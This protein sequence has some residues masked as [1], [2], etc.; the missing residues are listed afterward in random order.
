M[1]LVSCMVIF[2]VLRI[3]LMGLISGACSGQTMSY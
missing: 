3:F 2:I 1:D